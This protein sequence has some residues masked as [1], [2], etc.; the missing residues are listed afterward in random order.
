MSAKLK[1]LVYTAVGLAL[2]FGVM[3]TGGVFTAEGAKDVLRIVCDGF[4]VA[5]ALFLGCGGIV[6]CYNGGAVDGLGY[7]AKMLINRVR[8]HYE[9]HRQSFAEYR[10]QREK[11]ASSPVALVFSGLNLLAIAVIVFL[12]YS[13]MA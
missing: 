13:N 9:E 1:V 3:L 8:P 6:W 2:A 11:K 7:S 5:G 4:F 12:V 10:E